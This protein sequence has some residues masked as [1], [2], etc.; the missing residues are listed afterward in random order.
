M[1]CMTQSKQYYISHSNLPWLQCIT[2]FLPLLN[3]CMFLYFYYQG[4]II[5]SPLYYL[6][7]IYYY[8]SIFLL[9]LTYNYSFLLYEFSTLTCWYFF[10]YYFIFSYTGF[11][12][13]PFLKRWV[14]WLNNMCYYIC[15]LN[16]LLFF[17]NHFLKKSSF[18]VYIRDILDN[19]IE[20]KAKNYICR[21]KINI[22]N[23]NFV[24]Y[25]FDSWYNILSDIRWSIVLVFE[26]FHQL[27]KLTPKY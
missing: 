3:L 9:F 2:R 6:L 21:V 26:C 12:F 25:V 17:L 19:W 15:R 4:I 22:A 20:Q 18:L 27:Y 23:Y 10:P 13:Y 1:Y 24:I 7:L 8:H 14:C 11:I 5:I 16:Y